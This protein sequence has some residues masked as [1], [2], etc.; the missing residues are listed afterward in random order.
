MTD[1]VINFANFKKSSTSTDSK[2]D[3]DLSVAKQIV[4]RDENLQ[5]VIKHLGISL[6]EAANWI[7]LLSEFQS[8]IERTVYDFSNKAKFSSAFSG[9][10]VQA[11]AQEVSDQLTSI[12]MQPNISKEIFQKFQ[13]NAITAIVQSKHLDDLTDDNFDGDSNV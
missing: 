5:H 8:E 1:N 13:R 10:L 2:K 11:M 12:G 4:Q 3:F 9:L 7:L 6:D